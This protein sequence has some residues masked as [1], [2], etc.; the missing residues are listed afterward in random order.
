MDVVKALQ[1]H[2]EAGA[3]I[4]DLL[5]G[6]AGDEVAKALIEFGKAEPEKKDTQK[7]VAQI[8]N[9]VGIGAGAAATP[10]AFRELNQ[11]YRKVRH[12]P[13][14]EH[15]SSK[16]R[17]LIRT[18]KGKGPKAIGA[19]GMLTAGKIYR[20]KK[21]TLA[22]AGGSAA[23]Q[24]G[25]LAG[26]AVTNQVLKRT[27]KKKTAAAAPPKQFGKSTEFDIYTEIS[28]VDADKRQVFG[29]ASV[30]KSGGI[31]VVDL[32]GDVI[33]LEEI[34]KAAYEFVKK[35][36]VGGKM[37][38]K[39]DTGPIHVSDMI[40]SFV[41]TP[42]KKAAMGLPDETPEGWWVGFKVNDDHTW[43]EAKDGK[44]AGFSVHGSGRRVPADA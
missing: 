2:S 41:V 15:N 38:Q 4:V 11:A 39:G 12:V 19:R 27:E 26:D 34:E 10:G 13:D 14:P 9:M 21:V 30:T 37:H 29:W 17:R 33:P 18:A 3:A 35:S 16:A 20:N 24:V 40:E 1:E 7:K 31:D 5:Y 32:Q 25:N 22:L 43:A 36:R 28:K 44:L 8:S 23:L 42:E 6:N